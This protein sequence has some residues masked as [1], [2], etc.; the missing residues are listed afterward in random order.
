MSVMAMNKLEP[1]EGNWISNYNDLSRQEIPGEKLLKRID[2]EYQHMGSDKVYIVLMSQDKE[3]FYVTSFYGRRGVYRLSESKV[4]SGTSELEATKVFDKQSKGKIGKGYEVSGKADVPAE[5]LSKRATYEDCI[6]W[7]MGA[8][9]LKAGKKRDEVVDSDD[10]VAEE[11]IDGIR[12]TIHIAPTGLYFYSRSAGKD[13]PSRP[14]EKTHAF[15]HMA[16]LIF[17]DKYFG[18]VLDVEAHAVNMKHEEIA[19]HINATDGRDNSFIYFKVFDLLYEG[20][21]CITNLE[22]KFRRMKLTQLMQELMMVFN[23]KALTVTSPVNSTGEV[24]LLI[25]DTDMFEKG[26]FRLSRYTIKDKVNFHYDIVLNGG[27]GTMWKNINAKYKEGAKPA[28]TWYKWKKEDTADVVIVGFTDG[29]QGKYFGQIGAVRYAEYLTEDEINALGIKKK[30]VNHIYKDD[31]DYY[32]IEI[33][34]CSGM[35]DEQRLDFTNNQTKYI[36]E[37]M[38]VEYMERTKRGALQHPRFLQIRSDKQ[39]DECLHCNQS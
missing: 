28:N 2:L 27:E 13:D 32:L 37:V 8:Q 39:P 16:N 11:K 24:R 10:W 14:L 21:I 22:W 1:D 36:G 23:G 20:G 33:G 9:P 31:T 6:V 3:H 18:T 4:Y 17:P 5:P 15:A 26:V 19:G 25:D 7:P 38:E 12:L 34:Q 35:T 30:H 29:K